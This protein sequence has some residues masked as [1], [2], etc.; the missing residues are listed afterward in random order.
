MLAVLWLVAASAPP[1]DL[2][3]PENR[4]GP[5]LA[6]LLLIVV[7]G[8]GVIF[9][10]AHRITEAGRRRLSRGGAAPARDRR[11]SR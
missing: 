9:A 8:L 6:A 1:P 10:A 11:R 4:T 5:V 3:I 2:P 7:V